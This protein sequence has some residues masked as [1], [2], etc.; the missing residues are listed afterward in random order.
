M[1]AALHII[2]AVVTGDDISRVHQGEGVLRINSTTVLTPTAWDYIRDHR[3]RVN[4]ETSVTA[5]QLPAAN[6]SDTAQMVP[7]G[8]CAEP[9]KS[10]GCATDE[11]GSGFVQ[12]ASCGTCAIE[13]FKVE[14]RENPG[15]EGCNLNG[16]GED[17]AGAENEVD[18]LVAQ[19]T[20]EILE[21]LR[22]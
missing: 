13:Q 11:F 14:G 20:A 12:P 7:H 16:A 3:I 21:R 6:S 18:A 8:E 2:E 15:C 9:E 17:E 1:D 5:P 10:C 19:I 4:R 22:P